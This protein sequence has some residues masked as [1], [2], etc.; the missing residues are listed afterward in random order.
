[1]FCRKHRPSVRSTARSS[2]KAS[3]GAHGAGQKRVRPEI[4][5]LEERSLLSVG[6]QL[7]LDGVYHDLLQRPA[8]PQGQ[9]FWDRFLD[10]GNSPQQV[11][12]GIEGSPEY[13][14]I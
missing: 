12:F 5:T 9:A 13:R 11:V 6:N 4:E 7:Y 10:Q 8:E 1:M 14:A 3:R 2:A